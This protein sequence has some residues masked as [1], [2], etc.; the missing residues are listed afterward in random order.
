MTLSA[1]LAALR[2]VS[3]VILGA[4]R[5]AEQSAAND[6]AGRVWH[7]RDTARAEILGNRKALE[8]I[9]AKRT[10]QTAAA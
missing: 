6:N 7:E 1:R 4:A 3:R 10:A 8:W 2:P 9:L 5:A